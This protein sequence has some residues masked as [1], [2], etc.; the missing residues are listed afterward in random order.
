[1][2]SYG[3]VGGAMIEFRSE[4]SHDLNMSERMLVIALCGYA[5]NDGLCWPSHKELSRVSGGSVSTIKR[6]LKSLSEKGY[7]SI[8]QRRDKAGD[9]TTC[10]Y[11]IN[12]QKAE[13]KNN[14]KVVSFSHNKHRT[15]E[16]KLFDMSWCDD[17]KA[18]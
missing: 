4:K 12:I 6:L 10:L 2:I 9:L 13:P 18:V 15:T 7:I 3:Y 1:M 16:E 17:E 8:E 14:Q 11:Q 5:N